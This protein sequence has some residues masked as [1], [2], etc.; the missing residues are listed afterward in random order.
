MNADLLYC[1][2]GQHA[3]ITKLSIIGATIIA[4]HSVVKWQHAP[5]SIVRWIMNDLPAL[6]VR[7]AQKTSPL[8]VELA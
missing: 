6:L 4:V 5:Q 8:I 7:L 3:I 2:T 1:I